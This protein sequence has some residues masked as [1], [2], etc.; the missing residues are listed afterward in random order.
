MYF[1]Y[2]YSLFCAYIVVTIAVD[3]QA[4]LHV[5]MHIALIHYDG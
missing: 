4:V 5:D 3:E 2:N 1:T